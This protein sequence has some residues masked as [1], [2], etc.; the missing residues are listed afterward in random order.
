MNKQYKNEV[1][2]LIYNYSIK[3]ERLPYI[4]RAL[5][6]IEGYITEAAFKERVKQIFGGSTKYNMYFFKFAEA[7]KDQLIQ[8]TQKYYKGQ[9]YVSK[10]YEV[11]EY[12]TVK[13]FYEGF[14]AEYRFKRDVINK[15]KGIR[16]ENI[17]AEEDRRREAAAVDLTIENDIY[18]LPI[19][20]KKASFLA[21]K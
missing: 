8:L 16:I 12:K 15:C 5:E 4:K 13:I 2:K 1:M 6:G 17:T 10:A 3:G 20:L 18:S 21:S 9:N 7:N 14:M 19:Q 11:F